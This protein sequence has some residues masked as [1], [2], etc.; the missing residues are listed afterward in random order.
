VTEIARAADL[1][2]D[3]TSTATKRR[4]FLYQWGPQAWIDMWMSNTMLVKKAHPIVTHSFLPILRLSGIPEH[5]DRDFGAI[6]ARRE[7]I[8][9]FDSPRERWRKRYG[10]FVREAEW[11]LLE[12]RKHYG[13]E[14]YEEIVVGTCVALSH[15]TSAD[16]LAMMNSM[17]DKSREKA[18]KQRNDDGPKGPS[19]WQTL[20]FDMF[21]PAGWLT[22]PAHITEIDLSGGQMMMEIPDCAWHTCAP[23]DSLP[24]PN[25]LPQEGCLLICKGAFEALFSGQAGGLDMNFEPHLPETSCTVRMSWKPDPA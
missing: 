25:A 16:F 13:Q 22:G 5:I 1:E 9:R 15:E 6:K 2:L 19:R 10:N 11:A 23:Q 14:Q 7:V 3:A 21:N 12:L 8:R 20:A 18:R 4:G 17:S 24:D